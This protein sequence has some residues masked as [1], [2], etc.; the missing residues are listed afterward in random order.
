MDAIFFLR[1]RVWVE[2]M[3]FSILYFDSVVAIQSWYWFAKPWSSF[4]FSLYGID[5]VA[6]QMYAG[7][8]C[9]ELC[10]LVDGHYFLLVLFSII[11]N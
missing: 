9:F 11:R 7:W 10:I 8:M 6:I 2:N 5:F 1:G 3:F 4:K